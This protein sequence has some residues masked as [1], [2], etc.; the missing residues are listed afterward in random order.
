MRS[1]ATQFPEGSDFQAGQGRCRPKTS[2]GHVGIDQNTRPTQTPPT[3]SDGPVK[4][5]PVSGALLT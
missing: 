2:V 5:W 1:I 3:L 4:R